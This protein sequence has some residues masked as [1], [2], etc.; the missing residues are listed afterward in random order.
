MLFRSSLSLSS[1]LESPDEHEAKDDDV[2]DAAY[3]NGVFE[4]DDDEEFSVESL[5]K[6]T[7]PQLKQQLRLRGMRVSGK[8]QELVNRLMMTNGR[9]R[10]QKK[11]KESAH[12][13][14]NDFIDVEAYLDD[15]DKGKYAKTSLLRQMGVDDDDNVDTEN[16]PLSN[17]ETWGNE[18]KIVD[19]YEG[20]S[21]IVDG[22]SRTVVEFTG[23]VSMCL[24]TLLQ[25][26]RHTF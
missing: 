13:Q 25:C 5:N 20:Q 9:R 12:E 26:H 17:P 7:I 24:C 2:S 22:L 18:A 16:P 4:F 21:L 8:K 19:D 10:E 6:L 1:F 3:V 11:E 23:K 14:K 15:D